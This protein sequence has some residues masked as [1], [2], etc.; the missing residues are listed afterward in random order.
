MA[1]KTVML[2]GIA[3]AWSILYIPM[4]FPCIVQ[5]VAHVQLVLCVITL[6]QGKGK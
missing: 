2:R 5:D 1:L 4:Q 6:P 3:G